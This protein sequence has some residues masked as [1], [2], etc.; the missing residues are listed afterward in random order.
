M[1]DVDEKTPPQI[2]LFDKIKP[3]IK[4]IRTLIPKNKRQDFF[5]QNR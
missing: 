1:P 3:T 2:N 5:V 4:I